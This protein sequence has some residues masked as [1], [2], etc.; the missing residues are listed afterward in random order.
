MSKGVAIPPSLVNIYAELRDDLGIEPPSH[1]NLE[2]WAR[3]GVLLLNTTLT[4]RAGHAASHQGK[5]WR[6]SPTR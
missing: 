5:G 4:V 3:Q 1:G 6:S 2:S